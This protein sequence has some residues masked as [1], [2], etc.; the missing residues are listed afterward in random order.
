MTRFRLSDFPRGF[1]YLFIG[2]K[3]LRKYPDLSRIW[4]IPIVLTSLSL[5]ASVMLSVR[6]HDDLLAWIWQAPAGEGAL[7]TL[8]SALY[9]VVRVAAFLLTLGSLLFACILLS[10]WFAAPF[11]DALSEALEARETGVPGKAFSIRQLLRDLGRTLRIEAFKLLLFGSV[12]LPLAFGSWLIPGAG[13]VAYAVFGSLFTATYL[14]IDYIDWPASRR[15]LGLRERMALFLRRPWLMLGFGTAVWLCLFV[16]LLN[17]AFMPI[18][19]AGGTRL[20]L[21]LESEPQS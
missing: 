21:D 3:M 5:L 1:S 17:V 19:V 7:I 14:A 20:F 4:R 15:G 9:V 8:L 12:M 11:N 18:A 2:R 16:P 10:S 13:Q 6:Y